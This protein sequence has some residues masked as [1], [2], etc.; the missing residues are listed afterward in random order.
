VVAR[1]ECCDRIADRLDHAKRLVAV[2][3]VAAWTTGSLAMSRAS[4]CMGL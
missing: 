2:A 1:P 4:L 3:G